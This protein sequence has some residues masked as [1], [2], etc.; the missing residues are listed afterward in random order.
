[1]RRWLLLAV[2]VVASAC[3]KRVSNNVAG[4]D[5]E[6]MDQYTTQL[7]QVRAQ[8]QATDPTCKDWCSLA[9]TV[10][11]VSRRAC[12]IAG[13]NPSRQDMQGKCAASQEDCV[14]LND[15]CTSCSR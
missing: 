3:P 7:E 1:M 14:Q 5:D 10:C 12:E 4:S 6:Q 13:R 9:K 2:L 15:R 8:T 11:D